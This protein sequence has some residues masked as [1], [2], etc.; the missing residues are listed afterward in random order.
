MT[1]DIDFM[2]KF[3]AWSVPPEAAGIPD[4]GESVSVSARAAKKFVAD[5]IFIAELNHPVL[6]S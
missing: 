6:N 1:K 5:F 3:P 4:A 2:E